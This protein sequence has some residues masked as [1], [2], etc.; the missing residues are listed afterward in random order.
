MKDN[1]TRPGG[2][3]AELAR[4]L[5]VPAER[6]MPAGRERPLREHLMSEIRAAGPARPAAGRASRAPARGRRRKLGIVAGA[7]VAA[8][9]VA[10]VT[11]GPAAR[12][13]ATSAAG[14]AQHAAAVRLLAKIA[15]A[16]SHQPTSAVDGNQWEYIKSVEK[17]I[18]G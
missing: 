9:A 16:A 8:M 13:P 1:D 12:P 5:P 11:L 3:I 7:L 10:A 6:D 4:L 18:P 15:V 14:Q 2:D 17:V